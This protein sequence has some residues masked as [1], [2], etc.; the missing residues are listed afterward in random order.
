MH[1]LEV[2]DLVTGYGK[3]KIIHGISMHVKRDEIVT[4]I[5]PNGSGKSTFLKAIMGY[6]KSSQGK[7]SFNG[8]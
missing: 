8:S 6:L 2:K 5:G 1:M 7:I 3:T 4:I